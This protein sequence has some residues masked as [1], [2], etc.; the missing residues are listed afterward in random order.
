[1]AAIALI[2][3]GTLGSMIAVAAKEQGRVGICLGG[4][5]QVLFGVSGRR[6][7]ERPEWRDN[8]FNEAWIELPERYKADPAET[9]AD[10]W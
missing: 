3:A 4:H 10:Y 5:L 1:M 8:Y 9:D 2:A 7:R 6:W